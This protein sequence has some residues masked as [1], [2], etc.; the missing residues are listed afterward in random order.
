MSTRRSGDRLGADIEPAHDF[1]GVERD[2]IAAGVNGRRRG[3]ETD[4]ADRQGR[5]VLSRKAASG[6]IG[7]PSGPSTEPPKLKKMSPSAKSMFWSIGGPSGTRAVKKVPPLATVPISIGDRHRQAAGERDQCQ[8]GGLASHRGSPLLSTRGDRPN[9]TLAR[10]DRP[11][12]AVNIH[13][14]QKNAV[15]LH[16][17]RVCAEFGSSMAKQ[18]HHHGRQ[19]TGDRVRPGRPALDLS[20]SGDVRSAIAHLRANL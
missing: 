12:S 7:G 20:S 5:S 15:S 18:D 4:E 9:T 3:A 14:R 13:I 10:R 8:G 2:D 6:K 16:F 19:S 11:L 17:F 1:R